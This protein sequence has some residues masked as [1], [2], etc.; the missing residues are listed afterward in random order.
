[1][2]ARR[3]VSAAAARGKRVLQRRS[4]GGHHVDMTKPFEPP[5]VAS[6]H[7]KGGEACMAV[8]FFWMLYR[9]KEDGAVLIGLENHFEDHGDDDHGHDHGHGEVFGG[10]LGEVLDHGSAEDCIAA[11]DALDR[12]GWGGAAKSV[13]DNEEYEYNLGGKPT[14]RQ[15]D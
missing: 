2:F 11:I 12:N 5:H 10:A 13:L 7:K 6:W 1:M 9:A 8:M 3:L 14:L 15:V 4:F